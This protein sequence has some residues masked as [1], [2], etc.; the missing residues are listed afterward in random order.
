MVGGTIPMDWV[1]RDESIEVTGQVNH[2]TGFFLVF[3]SPKLR[4]LLKFPATFHSGRSD[5]LQ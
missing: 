2:I 1:N 3:A 4:G 5:L